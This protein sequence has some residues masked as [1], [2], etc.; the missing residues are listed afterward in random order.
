MNRQPELVLTDAPSSAEIAR[1]SD[2]LDQFNV[3]AAAIQDRRPLAVLVRDADSGEVRGGL[4]GRTSLGLM[5]VDLFHLPA[6]L[7]GQGLG[8][9]ILQMAEQEG[10]RRGCKAA[11][12]Y[13]IS[14]Q[15]PGFYQRHGWEAFGEIACDPPGTRRI[16]MTKKLA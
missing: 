11:V 10:R 3:D 5:F 6:S 13:T 16:F 15:A 7:R 8:S 14:F 9:R 1:I 2:D 4:T 12:L